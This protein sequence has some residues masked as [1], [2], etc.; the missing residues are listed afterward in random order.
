ML[1]NEYIMTSTTIQTSVED[2]YQD[3]TVEDVKEKTIYGVYETVRFSVSYKQPEYM[4]YDVTR[5]NLSLKIFAPDDDPEVRGGVV[6]YSEKHLVTDL[7]ED[8][9]MLFKRA[10]SIAIEVE[11]NDDIHECPYCGFMVHED[12]KRTKELMFTLRRSH[13]LIRT[14]LADTDD[15]CVGVEKWLPPVVSI[16]EHKDENIFFSKEELENCETLI[17]AKDYVTESDNLRLDK[18]SYSKLTRLLEHHPEVLDDEIDIQSLE[19]FLKFCDR[20][21]S[22]VR[23]LHDRSKLTYRD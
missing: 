3:I 16:Y 13:T 2:F 20:S 5:G 6:F 7:L 4:E 21:D 1:R 22:D 23:F 12:W 19:L 14:Q 9:F 17:I 11:S 8:V 15:I 10:R 18:M